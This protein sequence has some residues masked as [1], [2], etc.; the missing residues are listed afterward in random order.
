[1]SVAALMDFLPPVERAVH[2]ERHENQRARVGVLWLGL[3]LCSL[4]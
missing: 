4:T 2:C 1:M 3:T